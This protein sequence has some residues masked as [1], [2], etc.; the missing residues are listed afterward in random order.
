MTRW[1][2][3]STVR[4]T[5]CLAAR[6]W[7]LGRG[8]PPRL[9]PFLI[10]LLVLSVLD[11]LQIVLTA[12]S[13]PPGSAG[14]QAPN[15]SDPLLLGNFLLLLPWGRY[16]VGGGDLLLITALAEHWRRRG[17]SYRA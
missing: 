2:T 15:G 5:H 12:G 17:A 8:I 10:V 9:R 11:V 1:G 13:T 14:G 3:S 16:N 7:L 4:L 6:R